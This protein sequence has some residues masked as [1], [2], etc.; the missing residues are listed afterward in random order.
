[1]HRPDFSQEKIRVTLP[2]PARHLNTLKREYTVL[3]NVEISRLYTP[4]VTI[5]S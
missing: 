2:N 3:D 5:I 1:M 4:Q